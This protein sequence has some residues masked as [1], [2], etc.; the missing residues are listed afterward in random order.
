MGT[1]DRIRRQRI[2]TQAEGYLELGMPS[3]ALE[4]L[5]CAGPPERLSNHGLY[6]QGEAL[7]SLNRFR[8]A[9]E[10][11]KLVAERDPYN[12]H[13][14]LALGWCYKRSKRIDLAIESLEEALAV[15]PDDALVNYNLACYWALANSRR[16][17]LAFLSRAFDL[18]DEYR[19]LVADESDFDSLRSDPGFQ[20]L[21]RVTV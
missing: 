8:D 21:V 15:D 5:R 1:V 4:A 17:A 18:D 3:H 6:L 14:W 12:I 19:L 7:R 10:P 2:E 20:S 9:L 16:Q 13:V 11:L